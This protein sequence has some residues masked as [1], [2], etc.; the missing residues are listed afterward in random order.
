MQTNMQS[1]NMVRVNIFSLKLFFSHIVT[2]HVSRLGQ[3]MAA[4]AM[5]GTMLRFFT[6]NHKETTEYLIASY[7]YG[8]FTKVSMIATSHLCCSFLNLAI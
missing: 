1:T 8:S 7:K 5:Y 6:V 2:N 3:F 4:C